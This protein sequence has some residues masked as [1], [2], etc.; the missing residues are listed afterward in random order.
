MKR[1][2]AVVLSG[3]LAACGG[4]DDGGEPS[5]DEIATALDEGATTA[6]EF[7]EQHPEL[8]PRPTDLDVYFPPEADFVDDVEDLPAV[9]EL[10]SDP[11]TS[12][13]RLAVIT[14][15]PGSGLRSVWAVVDDGALVVRSASDGGSTIGAR[16]NERCV[17]LTFDGFT[18]EETVFG[19]GIAGIY[20][21][22]WLI[23]EGGS[24]LSVM[25]EAGEV[26][27]VS[28]TD[29]L[30]GSS[31]ALVEP[32]DH[33]FISV[34]Y[35]LVD[36]LVPLLGLVTPL[37][38]DESF[39]SLIGGDGKDRLMSGIF[40]RRASD[41]SPQFLSALFLDSSVNLSAVAFGSVDGKWLSGE[42]R[43]RDG[44]IGTITG[45]VS[46]RARVFAGVF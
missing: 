3:L 46:T 19:F 38:G 45:M 2:I 36:E 22:D 14:G 1:E 27:S 13:V 25:T 42:V 32:E 4:G 12:V 35:G 41:D 30:A 24:R 7:A 44:Q 29:A 23:P 10:A 39:G 11:T 5:A 40:G 17:P 21:I 26:I 8:F 33:G 9:S 16:P 43:D 37:S 20:S 15:E 34:S 18:G 28:S 31:T 6:F